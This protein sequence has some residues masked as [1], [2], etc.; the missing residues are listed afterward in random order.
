LKDCFA[1]D[2][3]TQAVLW[4]ETFKLRKQLI[5]GYEKRVEKNG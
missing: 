1:R 3:H 4:Q 5:A 2:K